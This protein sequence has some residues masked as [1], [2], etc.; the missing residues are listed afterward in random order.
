[1]ANRKIS[2]KL[3]STGAAVLAGAMLLTACGGKT[4]SEET[5]T[6]DTGTETSESVVETAA[7]SETST[8][9]ETETTAETTVP[10]VAIE[11]VNLEYLGILS[12]YED[13]IRIVENDPIVNMSCCTYV[14]ITG[15]DVPELIIQYN[16]D[17]ENGYETGGD[18]YATGAMRFFTYDAVSMEAV[19]MLKVDQ[20]ILNAGGGF[21]ADAIMLDNGNI[22]VTTGWGDED[23]ELWITEYAA[24]GNELVAV[25]ELYRGEFLQETEDDYYYEYEYELNG[26]AISEEEYN[27]LRDGYIDSF[28]GVI[29][30]NPFY[31]SD[32]YQEDSWVSKVLS[33]TDYSM[34]YDDLVAM[35][36]G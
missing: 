26:E 16:S 22:I 34:K 24:E 29:C 8:A 27:S 6:V 35:L 36:G 2:K 15:D 19:E 4:Q 20:T 14:D 33:L 7:S 12:E 28:T 18:Y 25:N 5:E 3:V 30:R 9:E 31:D 11:L 23:S 32:W 13:Q 10:E 1:M 17:P 21:N